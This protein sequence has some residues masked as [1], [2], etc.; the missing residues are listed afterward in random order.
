MGG[1]SKWRQN[2]PRAYKAWT[3]AYRIRRR[4]QILANRR[5][6]GKTERYRAYRRKY[7]KQYR[8]NIILEKRYQDQLAVHSEMILFP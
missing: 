8:S 7:L 2:N 1:I 4:E 3:A 6:Y 5:A